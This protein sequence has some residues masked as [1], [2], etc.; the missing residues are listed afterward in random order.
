MLSKRGCT[1]FNRSN[2]DIHVREYQS[3][4]LIQ[5]NVLFA[6]RQSLWHAQL[7][8]DIELVG[9]LCIATQHEESAVLILGICLEACSWDGG[10][11]NIFHKAAGWANYTLSCSHFS[12]T[13]DEYDI[14]VE[15]CRQVG[16]NSNW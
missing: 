15:S 1:G 12:E 2:C 14:R 7:L 10:L 5:H 9:A 3:L 16:I 8:A 6:R 4:K 13:T 11:H